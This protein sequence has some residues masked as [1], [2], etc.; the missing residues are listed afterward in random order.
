MDEPDLMAIFPIIPHESAG[1][2][3]CG[4]IIVE[5][6]GRDAEL[7]CN[8]CG[9]SWGVLNTGILRDLAA[10]IDRFRREG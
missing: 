9:R 7:L 3:C 1:V 10:L 4:C 2:N 5:V 6:Q 8:E